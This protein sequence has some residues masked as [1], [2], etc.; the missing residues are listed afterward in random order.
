MNSDPKQFAWLADTPLILASASATRR[1][2]LLAAG[3]PCRSLAAEIDERRIER[4]ALALGATAPRRAALLAREKALSVSRR[5]PAAIVLGADQVLSAPG[6][7]GAK[8]RNMDEAIRQ[9]QAL[10]GR[11]HL[12]HSAAAIAKSGE[13]LWESVADASLTMRELSKDYIADYVQSLGPA[14]LASVGGYQIEGLGLQLFAEVQG[15]HSVILGLPLF[16]VL[17]V[18][19]RIGCLRA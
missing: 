14:A 8:A 5:E 12:L 10:S 9:L 6:H 15:E 17:A 13:I 18:L 11:S 16:S 19:R 2:L 7:S 1:Q 3:I 4:E